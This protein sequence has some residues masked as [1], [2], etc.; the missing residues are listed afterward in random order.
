MSKEALKIQ[1]VSLRKQG[2]SLTEILK[3]VPVAKATLSVWF[4]KVG[5]SV[6][7]KQRLTQKR[8]D[9]ALR[10]ARKRKEERIS[11]CAQIKSESMAEVKNL[12]KNVFWMVGAALYWAEGA[13][14]K[15]H[16][17]SSPVIFSNSDPL[18]VKFFYKWLIEICRIE[19]GDIYFE[20]YT[21]E[22]CDPD[23]AKI[24]WSKILNKDISD[25]GLVRFKKDKGNPCRKNRGESYYGLLRV[26]VKR[27]T[28]LNRKI[29]GWVEGLSENFFQ[30]RNSGVV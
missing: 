2:F 11:L 14:Q 7:Q 17:V 21:H 27:S 28:N 8:L 10:G 5:L 30:Q 9:A 18:M 24:F 25:F 20:I 26:R 6:P 29:M 1:A 16:N 13:K 12:D 23:R 22:H 15:E 19:P 3:S 4:K